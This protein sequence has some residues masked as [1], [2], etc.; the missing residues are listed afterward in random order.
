M[1][2]RLAWSV[3][4][5]LCGSLLSTPV[6]AQHNTSFVPERGTDYELIENGQPYRPLK[7]KIEVVEVFGYWCI[8]CAHFQPQVDAWT[9]KLPKD[10]RFT[11][12]PAV[13]ED[14]DPF[15]RAYFAAERTGALARTH[16]AMFD[17]VHVNQT[18]A[19]NPT[20]DE[21]ADFY[22]T[23]GYPAAKM[24]AA[25][26][27]PA[28]AGQLAYAKAFALRSGVSGTPTLV[29]NGK[30]RVDGRTAD[31][32]LRIADALIAMERGHKR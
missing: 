4:A 14:N 16:D 26:E 3:F 19:K 6:F 30:Y 28:V 23:Q 10:V 13:F 24:K 20:L 5:L 1:I 22:A 7:G 25:M 21:L 32:R 31:D 17:A 15:A 27:A 29:I 8:H 18:L 12:V 9:R 2:R 11:Y